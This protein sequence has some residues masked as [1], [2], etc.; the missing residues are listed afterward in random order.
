MKHDRLTEVITPPTAKV[1][2]RAGASEAPQQSATIAGSRSGDALTPA[3]LQS[4]AGLAWRRALV[5]GLNLATLAALTA[6][7]AQLLGAG[8]W[9][10]A[11]LAI[12]AAFL[13]G[14]PWT[15]MGFWNAVIGLWLLH[16]ARD[17]LAQAA[18]HLASRD[19]QPGP[20]PEGRT[21]L[22][23][24]LR[25]EDPE[26][27]LARLVETKASLDATG[28]GHRFD[29]F[30]LSDSSDPQIL[31]EEEAVFARARA[32][33]GL[34]AVYRHRPVN[35]GWKAGNLRDWIERW[36]DGYSFFLPLDSDSLMSGGAILRMLRIM[37]AYPRLGILQ[38]LVVGT[39]ASSGFAR[40][41]QFGMRHGMRSF[42]MGAAWWHGDCG[43]YW[44]HNALLRVAPFR[45]QCKLPVLPG[46]GPLAGHILSHDQLE[47]ALMRRAG[48]EVR[49]LPVEGES[50]ED[51]PVTLLDFTRRDLR[52]C[53]GNMQY[54]RFLIEPGLRPMSRFQVFAAIMMYLAAPAWML[55]TLAAG[56]KMVAGEVQDISFV[57]GVSMFF[58]MFAVSLFPKI[59]GWI[60]IALTPGAALAYGGRL[61]FAIGAVTETLF[62]LLLAPV[63]AFRVTVFLVGLIFGKKMGWNGQQRDAY[64]LSW[65]EAVRGLWPQTLFGVVLA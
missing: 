41:F 23:M 51:N 6:L 13:I 15:V 2:A 42:T 16:A 47:A 65:P 53:Q 35:T 28:E 9:T 54:W 45:D 36:G 57:L 48:Y 19:A 50:W 62:S 43:P 20:L 5:V 10:A 27:A 55:M 46:R 49:V 61:R 59:A 32:F 22:L 64:A 37:A 39:P 26:R 1:N 24:F 44:G 33:L 4:R 8:G 38:S 29:V 17:G 30:V 31:R 52:W 40:I 12:L 58:I 60:D 7:I 25:N 3:G 18:P 14:A 21:A 34:S 11:D 63:V 56:W